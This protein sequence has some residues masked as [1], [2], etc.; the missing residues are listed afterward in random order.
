M[1]LII[2]ILLISVTL[3]W[4]I[5]FIWLFHKISTTPYVPSFK[6]GDKV[7]IKDGFHRGLTGKIVDDSL[8]WTILLDRD[9][10]LI[11]EY[12]SN[13]KKIK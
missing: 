11:Y 3:I 10:I 1:T 4:I 9:N 12:L 5:F 7:M 13:L 2:P 6:Y 8:P